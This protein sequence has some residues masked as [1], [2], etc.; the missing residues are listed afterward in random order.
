MFSVVIPAYNC[1]KTIY[2]SL[3]SVISQSRMDLIE[4]IIVIDDG[5]I[6]NTNSIIEE[7]IKDHK[8]ININL[9]Y[10]DNAGVSKARNRGIRMAK[11]E[12]IALLDAD[13]VW[14]TDKLKK[15]KAEIDRHPDMVFLG[16]SY[17]LK[18]YNHI[19]YKGVHKL[20]AKQLCY[21]N[22]PST[23]SIIFKRDIGIELGLFDECMRYGED[24]NFFQKF[25]LKD[26]YYVLADDLVK[27]STG[28][29]FFAESGLSSNLK[30]MHKGRDRNTVAMC[31]QG[32]ISKQFMW[33]MLIFN[34]LKF[35]RRS[36]LVNINKNLYRNYE[37]RNNM[38]SVVIPAYN[39]EN[40]IVMSLDSVMHQTRKDLVEEIIVVNDGSKDGTRE[41]VIQYIE[42]HKELE[43]RL[44]DQENNGV[45]HARNTGIKQA[46]GNWIALLDSD[47]IWMPNKLER[48]AE[49]LLSVCGGV[50]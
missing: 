47:D 41:I 14:M 11:A 16:A 4:E 49:I 35:I 48:Q 40:T 18:I 23:P 7:Y 9:L 6:D 1:E 37:K 19:F 24:I 12:W 15:Q 30:E 36:A 20:S 43:I 21:R 25:L 5:S 38:F 28:K 46:K 13:D 2:D 45:S 8:E 27:I 17:P 34:Q 44:I 39:C 10:Q 26:S 50:R 33:F 29:N 31:E 42:E 22:V 3:E 32:L